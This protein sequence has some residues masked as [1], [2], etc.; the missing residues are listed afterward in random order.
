M[1][2]YKCE[3]INIFNQPKLMSGRINMLFLLK[4]KI[5]ELNGILIDIEKKIQ[6]RN[7]EKTIIK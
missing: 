7:F 1:P 4:S 6:S 2:L 5:D 3:Y